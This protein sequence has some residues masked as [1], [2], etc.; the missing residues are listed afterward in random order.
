MNNNPSIGFQ[1]EIKDQIDHYN[2]DHN[3][4]VTIDNND[5]KQM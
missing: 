1:V 4:D 3:S 2:F 5:Y